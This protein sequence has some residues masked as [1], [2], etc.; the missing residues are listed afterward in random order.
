MG[1]RSIALCA[2]VLGLAFVG[3]CSKPKGTADTA[4]AAA[5]T[6]YVGGD[7]VTVNDAQPTVEALAVKDGRILAVGARADLEKAHRGEATKVV[8]LAG[9]TLLP[10]FHRSR[11]ATTSSRSRS[12]TR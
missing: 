1:T 4:A 6:I 11:T 7:I 3:G 9:K 12:P 5:D 2:I 8:D 10:G